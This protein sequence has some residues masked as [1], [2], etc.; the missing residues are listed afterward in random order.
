MN[1]NNRETWE[2]EMELWEPTPE[3]TVEDLACSTGELL[4]S[5][6]I[7]PYEAVEYASSRWNDA[8]HVE[9]P[10][11]YMARRREADNAKFAAIKRGERCVA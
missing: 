3:E 1:T 10:D 5:F 6:H 8:P 2:D 11:E 7:G 9:S 4:T